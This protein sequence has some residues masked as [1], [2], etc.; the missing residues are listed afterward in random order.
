MAKLEIHPEVFLEIDEARAWYD[1]RVPDLGKSLLR[2]VEAAIQTIK[3][4]PTRWAVFDGDA[5]RVILHRFP[6]SLVYAL[7][8]HSIH[9][10]ALAHFSRRPGYWKHRLAEM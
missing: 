9:I 2:E 8:D 7:V 4:Y 3:R 6:Y 10:V 5:R 1:E